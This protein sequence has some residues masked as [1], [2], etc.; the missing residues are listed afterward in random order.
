MRRA[1]VTMLSLRA[2]RAFLRPAV[3]AP[4]R[5]SVQVWSATESPQQQ[6][7]KKKKQQQKKQQKVQKGAATQASDSICSASEDFSQWYSDVIRQADMVDSSPVKGCMVIKPWGMAVWDGLKDSLDKKIKKSGA[8]N[9]YFPLLIPRSFLSKEAEHVDGF[10]KECAVVTHHRL[11]GDENGLIPDPDAELDEPLI[12]RPTSETIIWHMF[13][14]WISSHRDLPLK[15]NQWANVVRWEMRTRPFLR[16]SEFL[17]QEGHTAHATSAEAIATAEEMLD[18]YAD[19]VENVLAVPVVKG[20]KSA[21]E[22]FA[23][24]D[25]TYTIEALMPNGWALQSGTSHFLGQ[26]FARAFDVYYQNKEAKRDLVWATSWGVSTRLLGAL[27]MTHS[28]DAGLVLPPRI[29]PVQ[30]A[31]GVLLCLRDGVRS[32]VDP[33]AGR[34]GAHRQGRGEGPR[35]YTDRHV[36]GRQ[37]RRRVRSIGSPRES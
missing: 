31:R 15:I 9:A 32:P 19:V 18:V 29:A 12:I 7:P 8:Q 21:I 3:R 36:V 2:A 11:K 5:R 30:V 24:A 23:G 34:S 14:K 27:V 16:S 4:L 1:V 26:N 37:G 25:E 22:R 35:G 17:W 33:R 28:D 6:K 20:K 10:A 13:Q